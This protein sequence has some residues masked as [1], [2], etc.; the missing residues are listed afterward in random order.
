[1]RT[2]D[3]LGF[4]ALARYLI[5]ASLLYLALPYTIFFAGWLRWYYALPCIG[6]VVLPLLHTIR[7]LDQIVGVEQAQAHRPALKLC[8]IALVSL[9]ALLLLGV[10]GV[11]GYGYQDTDWL[12]HNAI[13][14]D[15]VT[16]PW[17]VVYRLGGEQV[18][19]VYYVAYYLPAALL[20]KLGGWTLA[21]QAL[22][23][24]SLLGLILAMLWFSIL[25]RRAAFT[26]VLLFVLFS[27]LDVVGQMIARSI[28]APIRPEIWSILRWDHIEQWSIG[29]QYSSNVTLIFWVPN[30]ALAGWIGSGLLVITIL[31]PST[32]KLSLFYCS[33]T[34]LWSPFVTIGLFP[35]L[36]AEFLLENGALLRRL[37]RTVSLPN[38]CG[39][40]LLMVVGLFYSAKLYE[41]SPLLTTAIPYGFSL[42]FPPDTQAKMIGLVL[43]L[44]FCLLEFGLY[45]IIIR[46]TN[47]DWSPKT[48]ILFATT[49]ICLSLIPFYRYGGNND[50]VMRVSIPALFLLA[51]LLARALHSQSLNRFKRI[52]LT[53]LVV[54]GA[55][56]PLVEF[57]RHTKAIRDAGTILR[58]PAISQVRSVGRW[59]LSGEKDE[60]IMLQYVGS[61][62]APFFQFMTKER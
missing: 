19:L 12:K 54:L 16:R 36:L 49:L 2:R 14:K 43:I 61:S 17:P 21:N 34:A 4:S 45:A 9:A 18:P 59:G 1:M 31:R 57:R 56:T 8:H 22:F 46:T 42:S 5:P 25:S 3:Q 27:G 37:K 44:I 24:W 6:L 53:V 13:L 26:V 7:E 62:S 47:R 23:V 55:I 11:G 30:Q 28:V 33:L 29:W 60:V 35:Y 10:S 39:L 15:L 40:A 50:F 41:V 38:L 20:G 52:I 48:K 51:I 32:R 58:T